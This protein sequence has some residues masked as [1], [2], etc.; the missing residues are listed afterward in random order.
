VNEVRRRQAAA[1][2]A[3]RQTLI[4]HM[5]TEKQLRNKIEELQQKAS[6]GASQV[7]NI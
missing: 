3:L 1:L 5:N 4:T 6:C 2:I 7:T